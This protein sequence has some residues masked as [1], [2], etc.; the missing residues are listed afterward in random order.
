MLAATG[1]HHR[2]S[3][4]D[5]WPILLVARLIRAEQTFIQLEPATQ[6]HLQIGRR[7]RHGA[8]YERSAAAIKSN[9][10]RALR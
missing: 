5:L 3:P 10:H 7:R 1:N 2:I 8:R 6:V 9:S 4:A